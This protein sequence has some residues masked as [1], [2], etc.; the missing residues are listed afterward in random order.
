VAANTPKQLARKERREE[1]RSL[2]E[3]TAYRELRRVTE[4]QIGATLD[5][6]DLPPDEQALKAG[7]PVV[8]LVTLGAAG[9]VPEGF[10][11]G[12]LVAPDL[13]LTN[14]HVFRTA[15]EATGVGAQ[16][17]YERTQGGLRAGVTF[18]LEPNRFFVN[19]KGLD[20]AVVAVKGT[21]LDGAS[22]QQFQYLPL[23]AVTGKI[24]KGD[25]VSIIQH[26]EGRPKQYATV[27]NKLLDLRD[28]GFLLYE[29]DTLEDTT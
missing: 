26:P 20:Y 17:L 10:A 15:D 4:R 11:T 14:H 23:I 29:T 19:H 18:E 6:A 24:A 27:N 25:P 16:F 13:L 12:F 3:S 28:D 21:A 2:V 1:L 9:I 5:F 22:L 7:R 8:R